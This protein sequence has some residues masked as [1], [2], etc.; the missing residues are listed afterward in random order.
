MFSR[1]GS[2]ALRQIGRGVRIPQNIA[3]TFRPQLAAL[4]SQQRSVRFRWPR[5]D[6]P[7]F[8]FDPEKHYTARPLFTP[9]QQHYQRGGV[10]L[11]VLCA[12]GATFY[13]SNI[14]E[15]P[16]TGRRR[17]NCYSQESAAE[18]GA[19]LYRA[20]MHDEGRKILPEWHPKVK[21]VQRV[22]DRLVPVSGMGDGNWEVHVIDEPSTLPISLLV[23][24]G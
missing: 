1:R 22:L 8:E 24:D 17:F 6:R 10:L 9:R 18:Q 2:K 4:Q 11:A 13:F 12:G 23:A 15:V 5:D 16:V 3:S 7:T 21:Q 19:E 14:E 20:I